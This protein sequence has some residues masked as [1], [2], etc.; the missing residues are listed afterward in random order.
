MPFVTQ[1][2]TLE[3]RAGRMRW[4][5]LGK[6]RVGHN[7]TDLLVAVPDGSRPAQRQLEAD[8][9]G[10]REFAVYGYAPFDRFEISRHVEQPQRA[11]STQREK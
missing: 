1:G 9:R 6:D 11:P 8:F 10:G 4:L 5:V 7:G 3:A 2:C